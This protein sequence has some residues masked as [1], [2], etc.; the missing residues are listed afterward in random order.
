MSARRRC[1]V[2]TYESPISAAT[3]KPARSGRIHAPQT[4]VAFTDDVF[5]GQEVLLG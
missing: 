1:Q 3:R 2:P 4:P 5:T